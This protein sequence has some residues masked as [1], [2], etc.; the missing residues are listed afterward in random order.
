[1]RWLIIFVCYISVRVYGFNDADVVLSST[2]PFHP[3]LQI[4]W[5]QD[6]I[7]VLQRQFQNAFLISGLQIDCPI[8]AYGLVLTSALHCYIY[9]RRSGPADTS[10][11]VQWLCHMML[12]SLKLLDYQRDYTSAHAT[13]TSSYKCKHIIIKTHCCLRTTKLLN[14]LSTF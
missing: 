13:A 1:M 14:L 6:P 7:Q 8:C 5:F 11:L 2:Q 12:V 9:P 3:A 4:C 10:I